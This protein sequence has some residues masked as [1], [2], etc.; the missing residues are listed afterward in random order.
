MPPPTVIKS[1]ADDN[2]SNDRCGVIVGDM[3]FSSTGTALVVADSQVY[4]GV[5]EGE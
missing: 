4:R 1:G 2:S 5:G 3:S